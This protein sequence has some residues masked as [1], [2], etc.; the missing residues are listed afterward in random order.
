MLIEL[1]TAGTQADHAQAADELMAARLQ[2]ARGQALLDAIARRTSP[3]LSPIEGGLA[4]KLQKHK[5]WCLG[6]LLNTMLNWRGSIQ[7]LPN[8]NAEVQTTQA[9]V[10]KLEQTAPIAAQRAQD[11]KKL[12][13]NDCSPNT[14]RWSKSRCKLSKRLILPLSA[15]TSKKL[16]L[17]SEKHKRKKAELTAQTRRT[18]L[19]SITEA[20]QKIAAYEQQVLKTEARNGFMTLTSP[21][22]GTVQQ[23]AVFTVGGVVSEAQ[24]VMDHCAA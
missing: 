3:K 18:S 20:Q 5:V 14:P 13:E 2:N 7:P 4:D 8:C 24:A 12:Q 16:Q 10:R 1:D 21:V 23:L 11:Y 19:D 15:V 9:Q 6:N 22:D 17:R